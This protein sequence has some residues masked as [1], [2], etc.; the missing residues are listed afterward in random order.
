MFPLVA[1]YLADDRNNSI[2]GLDFGPN[3]MDFSTFFKNFEGAF[4]LLLAEKPVPVH[5]DSAEL[6]PAVPKP[7]VAVLDVSELP[8]PSHAH[9]LRPSFV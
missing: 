3:F 6:L 1:G 2:L 7:K 4:S 8:L 5:P 9:V